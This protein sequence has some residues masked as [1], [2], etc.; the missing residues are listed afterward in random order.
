MTH[1]LKANHCLLSNI[2]VRQ[3]IQGTELMKALT[4][5]CWRFWIL[6]E[7]DATAYAHAV[8]LGANYG[9]PLSTTRPT[10]RCRNIDPKGRVL[11]FDVTYIARGA[12]R[13]DINRVLA[14]MRASTGLF[15][16][17]IEDLMCLEIG[18]RVRG[19]DVPP[20]SEWPAMADRDY[21][22]LLDS[23]RPLLAMFD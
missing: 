18:T 4:S 8:W 22:Q 11:T 19:S 5:A 6:C 7:D 12:N 10:L 3:L 9:S 23:R 17:N 14:Q 15:Y 1:A 20:R 21:E 13:H 16:N 2:P